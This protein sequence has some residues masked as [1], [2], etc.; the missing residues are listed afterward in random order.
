MFIGRAALSVLALEVCDWKSHFPHMPKPYLS[1]SYPPAKSAL[2]RP[3]KQP[4]GIA[5]PKK[6]SGKK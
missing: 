4:S 3:S 6:G 2:K 5:K 1:K